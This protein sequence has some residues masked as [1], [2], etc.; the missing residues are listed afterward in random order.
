MQF[1]IV[2]LVAALAATVTASY[3]PA[4]GYTNTTSIAYVP[5][6]TA[7]PTGVAPSGVAPSG[8]V[9]SGTGSYST[10]VP[11]PVPSNTGTVEFPGAA[12]KLSG[13]ALAMVVAGGV[14]LVSFIPRSV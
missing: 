1:S 14:A 12:S 11:V 4:Y 2:S 13:S 5:E 6:G 8:V 7:A 3:V 9:P 10:G